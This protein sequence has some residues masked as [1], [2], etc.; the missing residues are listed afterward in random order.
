M[1]QARDGLGFI[2]GELSAAGTSHNAALHA[3]LAE[4]L[5]TA[6]GAGLSA[7]GRLNV[8]RPSGRRPLTLIVAP[9]PQRLPIV[10]ADAA[11]AVVFVTDPERASIPDVEALRSMF[12]LTAAEAR[13]ARL[14]AEGY[15]LV[16][17]SKLLRV[18]LE[19]VRTRLKKVFEKTDTHRQS[20]LVRLILCATGLPL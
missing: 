3:L 1:I 6:A 5:Q 11:A 16:E 10:G 14:L 17:A 18:T 12:G 7:G 4:A 2:N 19:T 9:M 13:L 8:E 15:D 20:E